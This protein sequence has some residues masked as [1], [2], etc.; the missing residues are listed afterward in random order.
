MFGIE[1]TTTLHL[2]STS[3]IVY[4][5]WNIHQICLNDLD[6]T[7]SY[8]VRRYVAA[9]PMDYFFDLFYSPSFD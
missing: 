3:I 2:K 4:A 6:H 1:N 9:S 8:L 7:S 5:R